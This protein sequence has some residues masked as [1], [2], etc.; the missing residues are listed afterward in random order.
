MFLSKVALTVC[1]LGASWA[2]VLP[3]D[4][5]Q[6]PQ[7]H[8]P[9]LSTYTRSNY[10]VVHNPDGTY[11]FAFSLPQ[12]SRSEERNSDGKV[13]GSYA[14]VDNAGE[15]VSLRYDADHEGFRAESDALPQVPEDT[16]EVAK[17]R[18]EFLRYYEQFSSFLKMLGSDEE[19][20]E[21]SSEEDY[22][23]NE[24]NEDSSSESHETEEEYDDNF[25]F[26]HQEEEEE[27]EQ[28]REE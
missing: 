24:D 21:E 28:E 23:Y 26:G 1:V 15:E 6:E 10:Q 17:A 20:E 18:E 5:L 12:Q 3:E 8:L 27:Q 16:D 25:A 7:D 4:L 19:G 9:V 11:Y 2:A 14:F 13:S 22:D